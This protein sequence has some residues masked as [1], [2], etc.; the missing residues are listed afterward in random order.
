MSGKHSS[1]PF[2]RLVFAFALFA[3]QGLTLAADDRVGMDFFEANIRPLLVERCIECHGEKKQENGLRLDSKAGWQK[4]GDHGAVIKPGDVENSLLIKA[5]R[6]TDKELQMPP[7][8]ALETEEIA[9]LEQWV[10]MGAPDP[11]SEQRGK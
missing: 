3:A 8:H 4:G 7:K 5:V 10:R 1:M 2:S 6:R 9:A 11:R